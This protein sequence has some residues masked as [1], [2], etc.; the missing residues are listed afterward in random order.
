MMESFPKEETGFEKYKK[1]FPD[2]TE[3]EY[4]AAVEEKRKNTSPEPQVFTEVG[5]VVL[6][7]NLEELELSDDEI[8]EA[9]ETI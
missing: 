8:K 7:G 3:A 5:G 6:R 1:L 4:L 2:A 9:K